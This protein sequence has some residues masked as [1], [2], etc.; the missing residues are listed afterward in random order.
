M[1]KHELNDEQR[2]DAV[3]RRDASRDG[4]FFYGVMTTGVYCRPSCKSRLA[5]RKNVRFFGTPEDAERAG[6]RPCKRCRPTSG[7]TNVLNQ[8]VHELA[9]QI[10]AEPERKFSLEQLAKRAGYSPFHLQRSFKAIIGSSPKEYQTAARVRTL[11]KELRN[12]AP[13]ADAIYQAGFGS[14]SR[15]YEKADGQLGMT[16][17]EYRSG[18]KGLTLSYASGQTPLGLMMIG[19]T[20]RGICFLQF[21]DSER[22]LLAELKQQFASAAVQAMPDSSRGEFESWIAALNR[23]LRG[24]E[25]RL[26]LPMDV[27]GTAF[28]LI[29]WRYLQQV[30]YGEVRSYSEVA[31]AIGKPSA[32]RAVARACATNSV[33]LLIPCHRVVRGTGELG[34]YRWGMQRKRVLLDTERA[35][36]KR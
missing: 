36:S 7:A 28:Q 21:G 27:R 18:G 26:D 20:D 1:S 24:L 31:E 34:G 30:P 10:D 2:W 6:L 22:A 16:P 17:S 23:H 29:V 5:L 12:E 4:E 35:A 13:V 15:V 19:A 33:A 25:P 3:Q 8:V 11:K 14:G 9:R 32:A